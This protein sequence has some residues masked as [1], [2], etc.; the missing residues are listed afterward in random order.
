MG[1]VPDFKMLYFTVDLVPTCARCGRV[2]DDAGRWHDLDPLP[3]DITPD[4][5]T[6]TICPECLEKLYPVF[7]ERRRKQP[8]PD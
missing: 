2:R 6:H 1:S 8:A 3:A 5:L 4:R 7:L